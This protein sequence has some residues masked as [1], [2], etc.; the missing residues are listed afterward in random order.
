VLQ[1][2]PGLHLDPAVVERVLAAP[3]PRA[4]GI[5]VAVAEARALLAVPGVVGVNL[6][7]RGADREEDGAAVKAAVAEQLRESA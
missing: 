6:S 5:E 3:D 7:G 2:F 4:A 1:R